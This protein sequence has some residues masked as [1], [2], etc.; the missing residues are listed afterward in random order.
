MVGSHDHVVFSGTN[1]VFGEGGAG[2][3][4]SFPRRIEISPASR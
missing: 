4:G 2:T 1:G 3:N